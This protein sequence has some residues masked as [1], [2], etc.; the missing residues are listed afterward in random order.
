MDQNLVF[1]LVSNLGTEC[2]SEWPQA[3][4]CCGLTSAILGWLSSGGATWSVTLSDCQPSVLQKHLRKQITK[5]GTGTYPSKSLVQVLQALDVQLMVSHISHRYPCRQRA[6]TRRPPRSVG[7]QLRE[8]RPCCRG[9]PRSSWGIISCVQKGIW[10][11]WDLEILKKI[12]GIGVSP[13]N[14]IWLFNIAMENHHV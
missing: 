11:Q 10:Y 1:E 14:T 8:L 6:S 9:P 13:A 5:P 3:V 4:L 2:F 7:C 12:C